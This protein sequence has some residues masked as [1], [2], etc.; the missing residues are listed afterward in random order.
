[1]EETNKRFFVWLGDVTIDKLT[2]S[3]FM[4]L[5]NFADERGATKMVM[6]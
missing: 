6:I 5:A 2:K 1:L 4:N 3:T